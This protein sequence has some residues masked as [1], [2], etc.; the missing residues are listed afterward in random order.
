MKELRKKQP[1]PVRLWCGTAGFGSLPLPFAL[2]KT[3]VPNFT[4]PVTSAAFTDIR[5]I[6]P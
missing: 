4:S 1:A 2:S 3:A 6:P 5:F